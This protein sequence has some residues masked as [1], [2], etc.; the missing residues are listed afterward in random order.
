MASSRCNPDGIPRRPLPTSTTATPA[1]SSPS[2]GREDASTT[3]TAS[4]P[5]GE[6]FPGLTA[7]PEPVDDAIPVAVE[8]SDDPRR[9]LLALA[10]VARPADI[11]AVAGWFGMIN[12]WD[13]LA[14]LC[15]VL[16]SWEDRF[17]ALLTRM[18][19]ATLELSVAAPPWTADERLGVAA[20]HY[21]FCCDTYQESPGTLRDYARSLRGAR[22]WR[23]W[24]D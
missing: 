24:W 17:G 12:A 1:P 13:D 4:R 16:R 2:N 3:P 8:N 11:P 9:A 19:R 7:A 15:A 22:R 23:F 18:D 10:P 5:S 20:E 14:G 6:R 21:S